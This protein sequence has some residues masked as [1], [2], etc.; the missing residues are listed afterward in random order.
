MHMKRGVKGKQAQLLRPSGLL[1]LQKKNTV[2]GKRIVFTTAAKRQV[3]LRV[4]VRLNTC[5]SCQSFSLLPGP[6]V[7]MATQLQSPLADALQNCPKS[8]HGPR[9]EPTDVGEAPCACSDLREPLA[10]T[11]ATPRENYV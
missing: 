5:G 8:I 10:S 3:S 4:A 2:G 7:N 6:E 11:T 1:H 9:H